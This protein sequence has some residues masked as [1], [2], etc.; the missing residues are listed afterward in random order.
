MYSVIVFS[1]R[2]TLKNVN[3]RDKGIAVINREY[4]TKTVDD[5]LNVI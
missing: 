1:E 3:V 5:I 2:C 4:L